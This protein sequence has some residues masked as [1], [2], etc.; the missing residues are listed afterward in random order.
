MGLFHGVGEGDRSLLTTEALFDRPSRTF[1]SL[2]ALPSNVEAIE[3]AL[4]F[5][6]GME[7]FVALV[8]PSGWGKSHLLGAAALRM[9]KSVPPVRLASVTDHLQ[10]GEP[11]DVPGVLL[12]D[13]CQDVLGKPRMRLMLRL[14]LE[15]RVRTGRATMLAF[16]LPK[17]TR[18][19]S[20]LLPSERSWITTPLEAPTAS[21]RALLIEQMAV[22]EGLSL[23][24]RLTQI[25]AAQMHGNGR[26][27]SG[28]LKR[29]RLA[30][31]SWLDAS[32]TLR[33]CGI[34]DP[35]FSDNPDWDLKLKI[36]RLAEQNRARFGRVLP[37]D[38]AIYTMLREASLAEAEVAQALGIEPSAAYLRAS[39][40]AKD[41][42]SNPLA[43]SYVERFVEIVVESLASE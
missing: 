5:S 15:R 4:R 31:T 41:V 42:G 16:T 8:G 32:A 38:L 12:L 29:L 20:N 10:S 37:N 35:F 43:A 11:V 27:L 28:A 39:R 23:S 19:L 14:L 18:S 3:A 17:P 25:V 30:G 36:S 1:A 21:E 34:L 2:A 22:A 33:A 7:P 40:F 13:D 26:T 6:A 24:G 9:A